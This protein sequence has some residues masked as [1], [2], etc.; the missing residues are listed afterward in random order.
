[1]VLI[2]DSLRSNVIHRSINGQAVRNCVK[3]QY[4]WHANY[5]LKLYHTVLLQYRMI[6]MQMLNDEYHGWG[7]DMFIVSQNTG[8]KVRRANI[9]KFMGPTWGPPGSSRPQMGPNVGPMNLANR[10]DTTLPSC[11]LT[12]YSLNCLTGNSDQQQRKYKRS[13]LLAVG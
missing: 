12:S 7:C 1:M 6:Q 10:G 4:N 5:I 3:M 2:P 11:C 13:T 9:A 8:Y